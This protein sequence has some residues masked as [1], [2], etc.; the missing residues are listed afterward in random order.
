MLNP[1][2]TENVITAAVVLHN[3]LMSENS[4]NGSTQYYFVASYNLKY[5]NA[6]L[7]CADNIYCPRG[8]NDYPD[9]TGGIHPGA[10]REDNCE[11]NAMQPIPRSYTRHFSQ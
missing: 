3:F 7:L 6:F 2:N 10:W 5:L 8:Y 11:S 4:S 1:A 9:V